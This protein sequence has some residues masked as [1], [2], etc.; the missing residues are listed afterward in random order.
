MTITYPI[1][2]DILSVV[3]FSRNRNI[4]RIRYLMHI[5]TLYCFAYAYCAKV[6]L[7]II[8]T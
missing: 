5:R 3:Y 6:I 2:Y 1:R 4:E 8:G 7:F